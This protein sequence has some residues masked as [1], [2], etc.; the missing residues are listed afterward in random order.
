M[1]GRFE[2]VMASILSC[3]HNHMGLLDQ[4]FAYRI[5]R[6]IVI[7]FTSTWPV[8]LKPP[9]QDTISTHST[10]EIISKTGNIT[11]TDT[12]GAETN[13]PM[14]IDVSSGDSSIEFE[15]E[16]DSPAAGLAGCVTVYRAFNLF[17]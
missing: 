5:R 1:H 14:G 8:E 9:R 16:S 10:T 7:Y 15:G 6:V 4:T 17:S 13:R 2:R 3:Q 11:L 12:V